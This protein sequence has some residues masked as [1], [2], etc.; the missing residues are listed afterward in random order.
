MKYIEVKGD[1]FKTKKRFVYAHCIAKDL[2][3]GAGIALQF[4]RRYPN[5]VPSI[6]LKQKHTIPEVLRYVDPKSDR[7][8]YNLVTKERSVWKPTR[9]NLEKSIVDMKAEMLYNGEKHLAIPLI[10]AGLDKL[11]WLDTREFIKKTFADTDIEIVVCYIRKE[12]MNGI[13]GL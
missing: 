3:L 6:A 1:L 2:A 11:S 12:D 5:M 13:N 4:R 8:I 9:D 7:V 10:G